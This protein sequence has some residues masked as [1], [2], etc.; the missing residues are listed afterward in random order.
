MEIMMTE[1]PSLFL[2]EHYVWLSFSV[3]QQQ[4]HLINE[5]HKDMM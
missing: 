5:A 1:I 3:H 4:D 2:S